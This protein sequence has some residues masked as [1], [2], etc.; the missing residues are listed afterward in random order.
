MG[1]CVLSVRVCVCACVRVCVCAFVCVE[2]LSH[3]GCS[4]RC[5]G[6]SHRRVCPPHPH[7]PPP[8]TTNTAPL[9]GTPCPPCAAIVR[10]PCHCGKL[11]PAFT[12]P[13]AEWCALV[14]AGP[15][16]LEQT[17]CCLAA[18]G[19]VPGRTC[20]HACPAPC[21][22]G[23]CDRASPCMVPVRSHCPCGA[24]RREVR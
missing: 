4:C 18:C 17:L 14:G 10:K 20:G 5:S 16:T 2:G 24:Q 8:M 11:R 1:L 7:L 21:H 3:N 23:P 19:R 22:S 9:P 12:G 6:K 13:C 15:T